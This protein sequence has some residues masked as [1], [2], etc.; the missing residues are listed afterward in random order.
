MDDFVWVRYIESSRIVNWR[1]KPEGNKIEIAYMDFLVR[2][3]N[4]VYDFIW[5]THFISVVNILHF[6]FYE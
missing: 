4:R 3:K 2:A 1:K 6:F 5:K